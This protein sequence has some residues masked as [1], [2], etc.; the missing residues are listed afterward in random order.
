MG[1]KGNDSF[2]QLAKGTL[3]EH[4]RI[5]L[6]VPGRDFKSLIKNYIHVYTDCQVT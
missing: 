3:N 5:S 6:Y 1:S 2:D 4:P